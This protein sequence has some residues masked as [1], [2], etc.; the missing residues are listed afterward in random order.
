MAP[1]LLPHTQSRLS[2]L[3][4]RLSNISA[5]AA[6]HP[7]CSHARPA[8]RSVHSHAP[9]APHQQLPS[10]RRAVV[11]AVAA[12]ESLIEKGGPGA[13]YANGAVAKVQTSVGPHLLGPCFA[14]AAWSAGSS[15]NKSITSIYQLWVHRTWQWVVKLSRRPHLAAMCQTSGWCM[16]ACRTAAGRMP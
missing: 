6:L 1:L 16:P 9:Q 4:Q 2:A 10:R 13:T 11:R 8:A 7:A 5:A 14:T 3:Q 15:F 12:P